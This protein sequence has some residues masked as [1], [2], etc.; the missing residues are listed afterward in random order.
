MP[1]RSRVLFIG[2]GLRD[3]TLTLYSPK[4][5]NAKFL[6]ALAEELDERLR[7]VWPS[8]TKHDRS[9]FELLKR[10]YVEARYSEHYKITKEELDWLGTRVEALQALVEQVCN[11][12]LETLKKEA[13]SK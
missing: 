3:L 7:A 5:H 9:C 6:R 12:R 8:T 4:T 1:V 13:G 10:A 11:E 2:T